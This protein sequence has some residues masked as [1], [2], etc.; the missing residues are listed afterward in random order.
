MTH[1]MFQACARAS[2]RNSVRWLTWLGWLRMLHVRA[3]MN[4]CEF[5]N[6]KK[7]GFLMLLVDKARMNMN[8]TD[9]SVFASIKG[10][11]T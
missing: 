6:R 5:C 3:T 9:G 10:M 8:C 4:I 11:I 1:A 7:G 2:H